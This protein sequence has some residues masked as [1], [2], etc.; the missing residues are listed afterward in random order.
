MKV[1][2][3]WCFR[4][5]KCLETKQ[6]NDAWKFNADFNAQLKINICCNIMTTKTLK[7]FYFAYFIMHKITDLESYVQEPLTESSVIN[8]K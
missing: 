6:K 5:C 4:T 8:V 1:Y 3:K 2:H 7:W